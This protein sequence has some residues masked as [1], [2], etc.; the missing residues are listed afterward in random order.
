VATLRELRARRAKRWRSSPDTDEQEAFVR[1]WSRR[2]RGGRSEGACAVESPLNM[3]RDELERRIAGLNVWR[4][5]DQRAP[6]KPLLVLYALGRAL[7]GEPR[8][9]S[10]AEVGQRLADL[11]VE[12]GPPRRSVHPE[13]PFWRLQHDAIWEVESEGPM[14]HRQGH[15]DPKKSELLARSAC[16]GFTSDVH[17]LV[18]RSPA[19][20]HRLANLLLEAHFPDSMHEDI[21]AATGLDVEPPVERFEPASPPRD[22]A[23]RRAVL[24]AYEQ[25]C[26]VCGFDV[27]L[28]GAS[29][30]FDAAHIKWR[31][32]GGPDVV[33]NGLALC[34]LHHKL[35]DRGVFTLDHGRRF[36]LSELVT[37][38]TGFDTHLLSFHGRSIRR[39]QGRKYEPNE[40]FLAW[41]AREVFRGPGREQAHRARLGQWPGPA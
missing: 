28:G 4:R 33:A 19:L 8:L 9:V 36:V 20:A 7:R 18:S 13:Y 2:A 31:Q 14:S 17:R 10:Y 29:L 12:F 41:H 11:L 3:T 35:F 37:G 39:P 5:G 26:A 24:V 6:H 34:V 27:R 25:Q 30:G 23:F 21:L 32:A 1:A 40:G 15:V 38:G 22:P 16:G